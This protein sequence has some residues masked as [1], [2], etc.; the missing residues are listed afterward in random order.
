MRYGMERIPDRTNLIRCERNGMRIAHWTPG[1]VRFAF[2]NP[3]D[4]ANFAKS[5]QSIPGVTSARANSVSGS[6]VVQYH[7]G[8]AEM[9][10][11]LN[12]LTSDQG[13]HRDAGPKVCSACRRSLRDTEKA[14]AVSKLV[15]LTGSVVTGDVVGI[16]LWLLS[17]SIE[18]GDDLGNYIYA[19]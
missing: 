5:V 6:V 12:S 3:G 11:L 4:A 18:G 2:P 15:R 9:E 17:H 14:D 8:A 1:R 16:V 13:A 19:A 7:P 10:G